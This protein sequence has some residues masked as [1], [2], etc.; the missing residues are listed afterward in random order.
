MQKIKKGQSFEVGLFI[1]QVWSSGSRTLQGLF[2]PPLFYFPVV[3]A[4]Q[5]IRHFPAFEVNRPGVYG[6]G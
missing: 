2:M 1:Q 5:D 4:H 6:R 3:A